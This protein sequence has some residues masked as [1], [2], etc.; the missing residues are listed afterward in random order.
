MNARMRA[1]EK[2]INGVK[3]KILVDRFLATV[4]DL[5]C[6]YCGKIFDTTNKRQK[7]CCRECGRE[8]RRRPEIVK[9]CPTC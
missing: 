5:T 2:R 6:Q 9:T 7:F 3:G 8:A 4:Y 1:V